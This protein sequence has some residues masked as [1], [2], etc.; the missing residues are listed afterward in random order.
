MCLSSEMG[1][2]WGRTGWAAQASVALSLTQ[3]PVPFPGAPGKDSGDNGH[4][5][6]GQLLQGSSAA[7]LAR[8]NGIPHGLSTYTLTFPYSTLVTPHP[9]PHSPEPQ[10]DT[11][12]SFSLPCPHKASAVSPSVEWTEMYI[13]IEFVLA[14]LYHMTRN[15]LE[16]FS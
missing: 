10:A 9:S 3:P 4:Q 15:N 2:D 16:D 8:R 11:K 6:Q 1:H 12:P 14:R 5:Q 13:T 7:A